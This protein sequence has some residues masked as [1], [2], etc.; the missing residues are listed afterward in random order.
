[1]ELNNRNITSHVSMGKRQPRL[2]SGENNTRE[3]EIKPSEELANALAAKRQ[4]D[5][6]KDTPVRYL[7]FTNELG[8]AVSH[9]CAGS[10]GII[11]KIPGLSW[12][13]AIG[14]IVFD[15]ADKF[16][17]GEDGTGKKPSFR[18]GGSELCAQLLQS[19]ALPTLVIKGT[20]TVV[21]K[22]CDKIAKNPA[23]K[24]D[25]K[26]GKIITTGVSLAVLF[27]TIKPVDKVAETI[28]NK[29]V[30]PILGLGHKNDTVNIVNE[31]EKPADI[32]SANDRVEISNK[33]NSALDKI[34][35]A[36]ESVP[37]DKVLIIVEAEK[38]DETEA[39]AAEESDN[40]LE[41]IIEE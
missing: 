31:V 22:A 32:D 30:N 11:G 35:E 21:K 6:Y 41:E 37:D 15:V 5:I 1:M 25:G 36:A 24:S 23:L 3:V 17:K 7:G 19:V 13:P 38:S 28:I 20:Q 29:V 39:A 10:K 33:E 40:A 27:A 18:T 16:K 26:W 9:V 4:R 12:I 8:A 2:I 14:Y 34:A